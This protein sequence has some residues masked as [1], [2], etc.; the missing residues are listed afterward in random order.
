M[1]TETQVVNDADIEAHFSIADSRIHEGHV[2][3]EEPIYSY[4]DK[5]GDLDFA[6]LERLFRER[7]LNTHFLAVPADLVEQLE[8]NELKVVDVNHLQT[9]NVHVLRPYVAL[10]Y[11]DFESLKKAA[12]VY[13]IA[14]SDELFDQEINLKHLKHAGV[15]VDFLPRVYIPDLPPSKVDLVPYLM[16]DALPTTVMGHPIL[17]KDPGSVLK[18]KQVKHSLLA[19][20]KSDGLKPDKTAPRRLQRVYQPRIVN[21]G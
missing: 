21:K 20:V 11:A 3:F 1:T 12:V 8:P 6:E 14:T 7:G 4:T 17:F 10:P 18:V 9:D 2:V 13:G 15:I 19:A 5:F 16:Q